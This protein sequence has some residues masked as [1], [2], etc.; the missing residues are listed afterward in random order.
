MKVKINFKRKLNKNK[1]QKRKEKKNKKNKKKRKNKIKKMIKTTM[2]L[3][4]P[5]TIYLR[6][7]K[8]LQKNL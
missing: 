3:Q 7:K 4:I 5:K 6:P 2:I 8:G 1:V